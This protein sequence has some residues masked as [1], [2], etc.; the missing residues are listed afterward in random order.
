MGGLLAPDAAPSE[1]IYPE[2]IEGGSYK[3]VVN[4]ARSGGESQRRG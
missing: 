2:G 3:F 1:A 4:P